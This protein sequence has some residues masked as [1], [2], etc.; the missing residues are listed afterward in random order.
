[1]SRLRERTVVLLIAWTTVIG[2]AFV[3]AQTDPCVNLCGDA[4][5]YGVTFG[6][7]RVYHAL[8]TVLIVLLL[9]LMA[10][11]IASLV[12]DLRGRNAKVRNLS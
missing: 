3:I 9:P 1:M 8:Y 11:F 4:A 12:H 7:D 10:F 6:M 5:D 2:L